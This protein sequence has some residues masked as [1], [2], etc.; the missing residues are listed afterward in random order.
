MALEN[1]ILINN[2]GVDQEFAEKLL[3]FTHQDVEGA[4]RILESSEKDVF[5]IKAKFISSKKMIYGALVIFFNY[6]SGLSEYLYCAVS[7]NNKLSRIKMD[8]DWHEFIMEM[9]DNM[10]EEGAD[11]DAASR[12]E[13]EIVSG[14]N[15]RYITTYF[16]DR[17]N[18]DLVNLKRFLLS[19]LSKVLLDTG[20]VIKLVATNT[21]V[22]NF[23]NAVSRFTGG[24]KLKPKNGQKF[25]MLINMHIDPVLSPIGGT[26]MEKITPNTKILIKI[27]DERE[28]VKYIQELIGAV[29]ESG[30]GKAFW[31]KVVRI[32][33]SRE[34]ENHI[35]TLEF[36]PGIYGSFVVGE[37][38][39][40]QVN[41][42]EV[43]EKKVSPVLTLENE[44]TDS[45]SSFF[46]SEYGD[47]DYFET[48]KNPSLKTK[49]SGSRLLIVINLILLA[50]VAI[51][52]FI[53]LFVG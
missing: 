41:K 45:E 23:Q 12:I 27:D 36:G 14:D 9:A 47:N 15:V 8:S 7:S 33:Y 35:V 6:Q 17:Q 48:Q 29:D 1:Q 5:V 25:T 49:K 4:I 43:N 20:I 44:K 53:M 40:V 11:F 10:S 50:V 42:D 31:G 19:N 30:K 32:Q 18:P 51:I 39:R 24:L 2:Y 13:S 46:N 22:F 28:V 37:K 16:A 34:S 26:D 52:V 38:V 3:E 21:D